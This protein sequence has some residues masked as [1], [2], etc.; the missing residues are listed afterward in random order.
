[1]AILV[2]CAACG[3]D[4]RARDQ[5]RDMSLKCPGCSTM[6]KVEGERVRNHDVFISY[7]HK[8]KLIADRVCA[9]MERR[10]IRC[11]IAPRDVAPGSDWSSS[12]I[13][14][15]GEAR[16]MLLVFSAN[17]N[18]SQQVL[19]EVERAVAK[20]VKIAPLRVE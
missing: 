9:A 5:L 15:L 13:D 3:K 2:R 11:W 17:S 10:R 16:V 7:S 20:G 12:I 6:L 19:R 4:F 14:A 8:D 18:V 1:M